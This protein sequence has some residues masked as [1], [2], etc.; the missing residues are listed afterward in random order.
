MWLVLAVVVGIPLAKF[1][2]GSMD[3]LDEDGEHKD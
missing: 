1:I 2:G 3:M